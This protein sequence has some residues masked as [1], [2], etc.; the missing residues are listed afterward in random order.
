MQQDVS[1]APGMIVMM[2]T[3]NWGQQANA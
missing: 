1:I 2:L 3:V